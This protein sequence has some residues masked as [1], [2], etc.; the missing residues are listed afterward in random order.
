MA[1]AKCAA[2]CSVIG[3]GNN[4]PIG[5]QGPP[6]SSSGWVLVQKKV[7]ADGAAESPA[8]GLANGTEKKVCAR[9][10]LHHAYM[11]SLADDAD[12]VFWHV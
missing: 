2:N 3:P 12:D 8:D 7:S 5:S 4:T 6:D 10:L 9:W 1:S 11:H